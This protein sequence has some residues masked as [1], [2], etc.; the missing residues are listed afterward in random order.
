MTSA[1]GVS[2]S[3]EQ[4]NQRCTALLLRRVS[5]FLRDGPDADVAAADAESA[6]LQSAMT[7]PSSLTTLQESFGLSAFECDLLGLCAAADLDPLLALAAGPEQ[8]PDAASAGPGVTFALALAVL[9]QPHWSALAPQGPLRRW[10][11]IELGVGRH[12]T[13]RPLAVTERVLHALTGVRYLDEDTGL[14]T[15][16][17]TPELTA[18]QAGT[19]DIAATALTSTSG[20]GA[21][22][23]QL[24]TRSRGT[25]LAAA[26]AVA[27]RVGLSVAVARAEDLPLDAA[28]RTRYAR[29][30]EREAV[31]ARVLVAVDA[32]D[33]DPE[34]ERTATRLADELETPLVVLARTPLPVQRSDVRLT[35]PA[36]TARERLATWSEA[37]G[38][39]TG[40]LD[41]HVAR[42]AELFDLDPLAIRATASE[43]AV[44]ATDD[45]DDGEAGRRF[46]SLVRERARPRLD[47]LTDRVRPD[48]GW[49][50]LVL[51]RAQLDMVRDIAAQ[52]RGRATVH[53]DWGFDAGGGRGTGI[54]ALFSG[55]SGTGKTMTAGVIA[56]DLGLDLYRI[57]LSRVVSKYI[58]ETE[59]NLGTVFDR[60]EGAGAILLFDEADAL[61][62]RR[63]EVHDSH[64]RYANLEVSYLLQ[65]MESY[66]GLAILT[67]NQRDALD[68][69]FLRRLRFAVTFPF[70]DPAARAEIWRRV[71]PPRVPTE[72]L[73]NELLGRLTVAGGNIRTM[74]LTAAFYAVADASPVRMSHVL[75]AARAEFA[76]LDRPLAE[77]Q[78]R[79]WT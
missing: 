32:S 31:L 4:D 13:V 46:W 66:D 1:P 35:V 51:P 36:A 21:L 27:A 22:A 59:K 78:V 60:A 38:P 3:W 52:V 23:V 14:R 42:A 56:H 73:D 5:A 45:V 20:F 19:A 53:G 25:G 16:Q 58:G 57:D 72:G 65:R 63:S 79:G 41:R 26:A 34:T 40:T 11:I 74:A 37:L 50:D 54:S 8:S 55:P 6:D 18:S 75:R 29:R 17:Q 61:F 33:A 76:K 30:L 43:F 71:F 24:L 62:G 9:P 12:L 70:P 77:S 10:G 64:D 7:A 67:T 69:A 48:A 68:P 49:E 15:P 28:E 39:V 44:L 47:H 2:T